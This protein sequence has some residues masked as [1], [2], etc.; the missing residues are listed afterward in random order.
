MFA[1]LSALCD[2]AANLDTR[3]EMSLLGMTAEGSQRNCHRG[4]ESNSPSP[5]P[6][7]KILRAGGTEGSLWKQP[8]R[9]GTLDREAGLWRG[10]P[11]TVLH[12]WLDPA[13]CAEVCRTARAKE[14]MSISS[15]FLSNK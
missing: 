7:I 3:E 15:M 11:F 6:Q 5:H 1:L 2:S 4:A 13:H 14:Q 9:K 10:G 8:A 12:L